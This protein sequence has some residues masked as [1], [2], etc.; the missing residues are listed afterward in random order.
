[1]V[2]NV[3]CAMF[4][5]ST[6]LHCLP[7][8]LVVLQIIEVS[9]CRNCRSIRIRTF[10]TGVEFRKKSETRDFDTYEAIF[11]Q[12]RGT[13]LVLNFKININHA[14]FLCRYSACYTNL[15]GSGVEPI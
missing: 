14:R 10:S 6:Y 2:C 9:L 7:F 12:N 1:M 5:S 13:K 3:Y 11:A 4:Y 15:D 8:A